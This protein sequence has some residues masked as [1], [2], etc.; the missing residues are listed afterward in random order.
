MAN[1]WTNFYPTLWSDIAYFGLT[2]SSVALQVVNLT[3]INPGGPAEAVRIPKFAYSESGIED[4]SAL[5]DTPNDVSDSTVQLLLDRHKGFFF[6]I[7][8]IEQDKANV[9]LG[10]S[11]LR[12]HSAALGSVVDADILAAVS[13]FTNVLSGQC[14]KA[15]IVSGIEIMNEAY[16][17]QT[18]RVLVV[19]PDCYSDLLNENEFVR[20]DSIAGMDANRT[21]MVGKVLGLDV[22]MSNNLPGSSVADAVI[23]HRSALA[24]AMLR[25][26]QVRVFDQPRHFNTGYSGRTAW[27][28]KLIDDTIGVRID[29]P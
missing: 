17:P 9:Q 21:G 4:V 20:A 8:Y 6:Q 24:V 7:P 27:G 2:K 10:E 29:R 14:N 28:R 22:F 11:V 23:M 18:D 1:T 16:A 12:Q 25:Q 5:I 13:G 26:V 3:W 15:T 19:S